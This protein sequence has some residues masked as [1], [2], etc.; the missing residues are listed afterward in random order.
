M[1]IVYLSSDAFLSV[2]ALPAKEAVPALLAA[3]GNLDILRAR[4]LALFCSVKCPGPLILQTYEAAQALRE[5]GVTIISGF[6]SP[7]EQ[8]CLRLLL[9][10]R[11]P[12]IIC[13]ARSL[14]KMRLPQEWQPALAEGRLLLLSPFTE[15]ARRPT[16]QLARRRNEC[17]AALADEILVAYAEPGGKTEQFCRQMLAQAKSLLMFASPEHA[18]LVAAGAKLTNAEALS[19]RWQTA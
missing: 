4:K 1:E 14:E 7:M 15:K 12:V 16:A 5:A 2:P 19:R 10:G 13:P 3:S 6:H 9:R 8:E 17:V 11:Q 18:A